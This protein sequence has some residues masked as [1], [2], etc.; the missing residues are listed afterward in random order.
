MSSSLLLSG[1]HGH[2][3]NPVEL[4]TADHQV[5]RCSP[6]GERRVQPGKA[7][8][9]TVQTTAQALQMDKIMMYCVLLGQVLNW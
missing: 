4:A 8:P 1:L 2:T 3:A 9:F 5:H 7:L 6:E